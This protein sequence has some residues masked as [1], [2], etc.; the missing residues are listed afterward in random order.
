[1]HRQR[2]EDHA[3]HEASYASRVHYL[4]MYA[5]LHAISCCR[6]SAEQRVYMY[7][8]LLCVITDHYSYNMCHCCRLLASL[9]MQKQQ[10][11]EVPAAV[12]LGRVL[13]GLAW[14]V[15]WL[16]QHLKHRNDGAAC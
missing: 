10:Q 12:M 15:V 5:C 13:L 9:H 16:L 6:I 7:M 14:I 1:M 11:N 8:A 3:R 4:S 2:G